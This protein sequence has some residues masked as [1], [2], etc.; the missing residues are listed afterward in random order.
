MCHGGLWCLC[1]YSQGA[2]GA[3]ET[4]NTN[5]THKHT[6]TH[7]LVFTSI[8]P[9]EVELE[10]TGLKQKMY[11]LNVCN[12]LGECVSSL[13]FGRFFNQWETNMSTP[14]ISTVC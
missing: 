10:M 14:H 9:V 11:F 1:S 3:D 2:K 5:E 6:Y 8:F 13:K 12:I 7:M 4:F